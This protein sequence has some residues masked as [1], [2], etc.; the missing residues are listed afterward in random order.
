[1]AEIKVI[2]NTIYLEEEN[3]CGM[4]FELFDDKG[5]QVFLGDAPDGIDNWKGRIEK[6]GNYK[7]KVLMSCL[8]S[9]STADLRKKKP[10]F[11]YSLVVQTK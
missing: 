11:K 4:Y 8:G 10:R 2:S 3:G 7:I 5:E 1:M 6:T 9:Y